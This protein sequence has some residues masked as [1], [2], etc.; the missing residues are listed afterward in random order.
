MIVEK[1]AEGKITKT[2]IIDKNDQQSSAEINWN[3]D[4]VPSTK[5]K[6]YADDPAK[7][8][9]KLGKFREVVKKHQGL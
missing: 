8:D 6:V 4:G 2:T 3:K 5:I 1:D 9:E 7:L